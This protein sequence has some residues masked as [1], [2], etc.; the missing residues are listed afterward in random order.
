MLSLLFRYHN[1]I[2]SCNVLKILETPNKYVH[3]EFACFNLVLLS[4]VSEANY[5]V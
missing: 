5:F 2:N 1:V 4:H 3:I